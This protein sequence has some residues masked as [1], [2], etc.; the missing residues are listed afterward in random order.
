MQTAAQNGAVRG[1]QKRAPRELESKSIE[2][3]AG[4]SEMAETVHAA[5]QKRLVLQ[6]NIEQR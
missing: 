5:L 4:S 6:C 1:G 2:A 3:R